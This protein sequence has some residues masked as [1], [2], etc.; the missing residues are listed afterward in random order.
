MPNFDY[1]SR[2]YYS[3]RED[4][5]ARADQLPIGNSWTTRSES[6]FGVL[7][8]DLWA[9]MGDVLHFY[10]DRAAAETFLRTASQRE[11]VIALANLLDYEFLPKTSAEATVT[12]VGTNAWAGPVNIPKYTT[13]VAPSRTSTETTHYYVSTMS[14][15]MGASSSSVT[16]P[17]IEGT[18]IIDELPK[19]VGTTLGNISNGTPDQ[20]FNLSS[21]NV[22]TGTLEVD[23]YEGPLGIDNTPTA[24]PYV[25]VS[26]I[27]EAE[28]YERA[29]TLSTSSDNVVQISFGNGLNGRIPANGAEIKATYVRSTGSLGNIAENRITSFF[30]NTLVGVRVLSST[31][32]SGGFDDE[33]IV[34]MKANIPLLFRT[35]DRAVSIQDF[36]DLSLRVPGVSKATA[37]NVGGNVTIYPVVYQPD[38]L[39]STFGNTITITSAV[40]ESAI[41]YFEPRM[42]IGASVGVAPSVT[43]TPVY[44]NADINIKDGYV[45][46]WIVDAV[47]AALDTIFDFD[48]VSFGQVLSLGQIYRTILG[49]DG[50]D[51]VN[52]TGFNTVNVNTIPNNVITANATRLLRKGAYDLAGISGG[53]T[54]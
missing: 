53:V 49:I 37:S 3:I 26:R 46:K 8:V 13:F 23:V 39:S 45:Q 42:M 50:V 52:I 32:A 27:T 17:V 16:I 54:G 29:F 48:N 33:T 47:T 1:T 35:Q 18:A 34:S 31:P 28:S 38:Y 22:L 9:Y 10:V 15:S 5:L 11:S 21:Y 2:D 12:I 7:L 20:R 6:D 51:Y 44:I 24:V 19:S 40:Q 4:L 41:S 14:A 36:K 30:E 43:L 25:Y